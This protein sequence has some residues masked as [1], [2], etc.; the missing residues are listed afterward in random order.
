M[1]AAGRIASGGTKL[2][3]GAGRGGS[4]GAGAGGIAAS[5]ARN[6]PAGAGAGGAAR[7]DDHTT[8]AAAKGTGLRMR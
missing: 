7:P 5:A 4:T 2:S 1:V 6:V 8:H 3:I